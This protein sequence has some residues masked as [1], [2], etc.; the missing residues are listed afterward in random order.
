MLA[1]KAHPRNSDK[2]NGFNR[3]NIDVVYCFYYKNIVAIR[4][5]EVL[6]VIIAARHKGHAEWR[7]ALN[8]E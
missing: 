1:I 5:V 3:F 2:S 8:L 4:N 6:G 7:I